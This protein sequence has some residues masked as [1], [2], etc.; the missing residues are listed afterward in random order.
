MSRSLCLV[1]WTVGLI[2]VEIEQ[3]FKR[4]EALWVSDGITG[5]TTIV[6]RGKPKR[7]SEAMLV[8]GVHFRPGAAAD[9]S[10]T[11]GGGD[12]NSGG[13]L[14]VHG[15]Q[16]HIR[17]TG[18]WQGDQGGGYP[19]LVLQEGGHFTIAAEARIDFVM[20]ENFFTRQLWVW[21]DGSGVLELEP[22]FIADRSRGGQEPDAM[23]TIR[24]AGATLISHATHSL[25]QHAR[26]DGR[27]G[28]YLNG[29]VV[30][31]G[32]RP[33]TWSVQS[34]AQ[35]YGAQ[36][37][38][39]RDGTIDCQAPLTHHGQLRRCLPVGNGGHFVSSGAFRTRSAGVTIRK[40]GA[41]MLSLEG[42]QAYQPG[43][44]LVVEEGLLRLYSDPAAGDRVDAERYGDHLQ[45]VVRPGASLLLAAPLV[46]LASL[47]VAAGATVWQL[48]GCRLAVAGE[49][50]VAAGAEWITGDR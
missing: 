20:A 40:T 7:Y 23:G 16:G 15:P 34:E 11:I 22:G 13:L 37:D 27:G 1:L 39:S 24:L 26:P 28:V 14:G 19:M 21:G 42:Q 4:D 47:E 9:L 5:I 31:E 3:D 46:R 36:I 18:V 29:H 6:Q 33:S 48:D 38:F 25:P 35:W 12:F 8:D 10:A 30:F 43:A 44:R 2:A 17:F 32:D 41:A 50:L 45:L 49:R